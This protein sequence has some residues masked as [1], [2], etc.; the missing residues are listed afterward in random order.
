MKLLRLLSE[1]ALESINA[2]FLVKSDGEQDGFHRIVVTLISGSLGVAASAKKKTVEERL[3]FA[4][5]GAAEFAPA[6][7]GVVDQLNECGNGAAH[8]N[9]RRSCTSGAKALLSLKR[10]RRG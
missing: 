6:R 9:L 10:F 4:A 2:F 1:R 8:G 7:G 5:Q 3:V